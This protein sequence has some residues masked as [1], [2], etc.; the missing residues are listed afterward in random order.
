MMDLIEI[1]LDPSLTCLLRV[2]RAKCTVV[3]EY[4]TESFLSRRII[5]MGGFFKNPL[6]S[7]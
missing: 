1:S 6:L 7:F 5:K 2:E 4:G 3:G